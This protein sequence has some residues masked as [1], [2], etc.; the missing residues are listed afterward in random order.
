MRRGLAVGIVTALG[1]TLGGTVAWADTST[2]AYST[3]VGAVGGYGYTAF[4]T[5]TRNG[6]AADVYS[7]SVGG[8]YVLSARTNSTSTLG[9]W[10][11]YVVSDGTTHVLYNSQ[12]AGT[13]V[14]AQFRNRPQTPVSVQASGTWRSN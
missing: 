8:S 12:P 3:T 5:K 11:G 9:T 7:S 2:A 14:R 4:Q 1:L 13:Q 10:T 6:Q